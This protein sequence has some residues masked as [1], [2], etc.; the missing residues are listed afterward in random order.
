MELS[1]GE[2]EILGCV[3]VCVHVCTYVCV[4]LLQPSSPKPEPPSHQAPPLLAQMP[5]T[6]LL[7]SSFILKGQP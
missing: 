3:C 1:W 7:F 4:H 2:E 5:Q 6:P